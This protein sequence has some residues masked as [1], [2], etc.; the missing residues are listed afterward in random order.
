MLQVQATHGRHQRC[1]SGRA[2]ARDGG[3]V[4]NQKAIYQVGMGKSQPHR[5]FP[6]Q[7]V[8]HQGYGFV[9]VLPQPVG[10]VLGLTI[11]GETYCPGRGAVI[12]QV[13]QMAGRYLGQGGRYSGEILALTEQ[14]VQEHHL[15]RARS[16]GDSV[17][18]R[19]SLQQCECQWRRCSTPESKPNPG[20]SGHAT[21]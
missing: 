9:E 1:E 7:R 19:F 12:G 14:A 11:Q 3:D 10:Y 15:R 8:S 4:R 5:Q 21:R 6:T 16:Y 2:I 13:E 18:H 20:S 17:D